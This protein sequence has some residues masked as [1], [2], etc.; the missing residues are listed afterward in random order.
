MF[1]PLGIAVAGAGTF[2]STIWATHGPDIFGAVV[3]IAPTTRPRN[4]S[5][6]CMCACG[7]DTTKGFCSI[8]TAITTTCLAD[9]PSP[10]EMCTAVCSR[11]IYCGCTNQ[12]RCQ[13]S[14]HAHFEKFAACRE[15]LDQLLF[16]AYRHPSVSDGDGIYGSPDCSIEQQAVADCGAATFMPFVARHA[17]G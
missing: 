11:W 9:R 16:C 12:D 13:E 3:L 7:D 2:Y 6:D 8:G 5:A 10:E 14:C 15:Q 17:C 1:G 4:N